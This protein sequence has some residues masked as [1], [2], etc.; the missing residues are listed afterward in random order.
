MRNAPPIHR[1]ALAFVAAALLLWW[2]VAQYRG[3]AAREAERLR[4]SDPAMRAAA[5]EPEVERAEFFARI[6][7][8]AENEIMPPDY[9]RAARLYEE[10]IRRDPHQASVW[11][12]L[13]NVRLFMGEKAKA[14]AALRHA[15][16]VD[17]NNPRRRLEALPMWVLLGERDHAA[18]SARHV[19][20]LGS[21]LMVEAARQL[22]LSGFEAPEVFSLLG[23]AKME[24]A[25]QVQLLSVLTSTSA[26]QNRALVEA[27]PEEALRDASLGRQAALLLMNPVQEEPLLALWRL[28]TASDLT[29]TT[30]GGLVLSA[31][32]LLR[33]GVPDAAG[34]FPLGWQATPN[35]PHLTAAV[36]PS[37]D[38]YTT[39]PLAVRVQ[40]DSFAGMDDRERTWDFHR[41]LVPAGAAL[42]LDF[43]VK[44]DPPEVSKLWFKAS[45]KGGEARSA[46][47]DTFEADWQLVRLAVPAADEPRVVTLTVARQARTSVGIATGRAWFSPDAAYF[48]RNSLQTISASAGKNF[49]T[50]P[51]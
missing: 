45:W 34:R 38:R 27:L 3:S 2:G 16:A 39:S 36:V 23:G 30:P 19:A 35:S 41:L 42:P 22:R 51:R 8:A 1:L 17:P 49:S 20:D 18:E 12:R 7:S 26:G 48:L 37:D 46:T 33:D 32:L 4:L 14:V 24:L 10:S 47:A 40:Y 15:E 50:T 21:D 13:A 6:A 25:A 5:S 29:P 9:T 28:Q 44:L 31:N 11:I 43:A